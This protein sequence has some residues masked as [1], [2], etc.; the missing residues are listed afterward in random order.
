[1]L[2]QS[3]HSI[4]QTSLQGNTA[5]GAVA[6][7]AMQVRKQEHNWKRERPDKRSNP[8][9]DFDRAS[10]TLSNST[11]KVDRTDHQQC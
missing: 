1:L 10:A 4:F 5:L 9:P 3:G 6:V 11:S 8:R 2:A 7:L